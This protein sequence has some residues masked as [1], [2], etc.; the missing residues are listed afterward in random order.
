MC[1][2]SRPPSSRALNSAA[3]L[4]VT[5]TGPDLLG[6]PGPKID[7]TMWVC[8]YPDARR[9]IALHFVFRRRSWVE[10]LDEA[11]ARHREVDAAVRAEE[12]L[13]LI[14]WSEA[15]TVA[16]TAEPGAGVGAR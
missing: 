13:P 10:Q 1:H 3:S 8:D 6:Q 9:L 2:H 5:P 4:N 16:G 11:L 15:P 12:G 7:E 14:D